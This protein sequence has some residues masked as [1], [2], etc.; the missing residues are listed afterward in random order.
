LTGALLL[1]YGFGKA[2]GACRVHPFGFGEFLKLHDHLT[3]V[4]QFG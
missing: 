2:Q 4:G 3:Q 1:R